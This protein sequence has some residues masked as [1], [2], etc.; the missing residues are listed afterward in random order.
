MK[1]VAANHFV[2]LEIQQLLNGRKKESLRNR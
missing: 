2:E 1:E